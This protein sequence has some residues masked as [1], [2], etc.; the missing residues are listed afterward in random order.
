MNPQQMAND[1][2]PLSSGAATA[3][4]SLAERVQL[5][6]GAGVL[7]VV[8][9]ALATCIPIYGARDEQEPL[10]RLSDAD[11]AG[12]RFIDG[13]AR[14]HFPS[15]ATPFKRLAVRAQ[16]LAS[17]IERLKRAG[18]NFSQARFEPAPRRIPRVVP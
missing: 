17:A 11:V 5:P 2:V 1:L 4:L 9:I 8:A 3:Y 13:A 15:G 10:S 14:L 12:G 16:D 7:D 18:V 6:V